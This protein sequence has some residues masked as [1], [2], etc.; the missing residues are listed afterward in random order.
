MIM[1]RGNVKTQA[2]RSGLYLAATSQPSPCENPACSGHAVAQE[3]STGA[4]LCQACI[5]SLY[6]ARW[7]FGS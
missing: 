7:G 2:D 3:Q 4:W 6:D 1:H 5:D